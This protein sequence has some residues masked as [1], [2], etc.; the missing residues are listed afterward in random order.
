MYYFY[1]FQ[2][3]LS[4]LMLKLCFLASE[5]VLVTLF[6]VEAQVPCKKEIVETSLRINNDLAL[7]QATNKTCDLALNTSAGALI[8]FKFITTGLNIAQSTLLFSGCLLEV[9]ENSDSVALIIKIN[10]ST[11]NLTLIYR[12]SDNCNH[13]DSIW[14]RVLIY[15]NSPDWTTDSEPAPP[16][17]IPK[18]AVPMLIPIIVS[19]LILLAIIFGFLYCYSNKMYIF[20]DELSTSY[21]TTE[22]TSTRDKMNPIV[23]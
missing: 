3:L 11:T 6:L 14:C 4:H 19:L 20:K 1:F 10:F 16:D 17:E 18:A 9:T 2:D 15:H 5:F 22:S 13:M 12:Y 21:I 23:L 8:L 7:L